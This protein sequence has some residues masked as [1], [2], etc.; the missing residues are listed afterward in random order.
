MDALEKQNQELK[1][2]DAI[3]RSIIMSLGFEVFSAK[4]VIDIPFLVTFF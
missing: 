4:S 2:Y 3:V 1:V